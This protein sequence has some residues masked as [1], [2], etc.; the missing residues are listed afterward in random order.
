MTFSIMNHNIMLN[1]ILLSV[2]MLN[3]NTL[4]VQM[5]SVILFEVKIQSHSLQNVF[6]LS[7]TLV[8]IIILR[9]L[10][11]CA[12]LFIVI[13]LIVMA[14]KTTLYFSFTGLDPTCLAT[15]SSGHPM[16]PTQTPFHTWYQSYKTVF[17]CH[18][19]SR[20]VFTNPLM[21]N[22]QSFFKVICLNIRWQT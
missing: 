21:T 20:V 6:M 17:L 14:L 19:C 18:S 4:N 15:L 3:A 9:I 2:I 5:L 1:V 8:I 7:V 13:I 11:L 12:I 22:L 16:S 10:L